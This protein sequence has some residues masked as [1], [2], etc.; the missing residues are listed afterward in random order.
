MNNIVKSLCGG[1]GRYSN[2]VSVVR[3]SADVSIILTFYVLGPFKF[4]W[5]VFLTPVCSTILVQVKIDI[6]FNETMTTE[7]VVNQ[8]SQ[9]KYSP[10]ESKK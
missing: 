1:V 7:D 4:T 2:R 5:P 6:P 3:F 9:F 10:V 8:V